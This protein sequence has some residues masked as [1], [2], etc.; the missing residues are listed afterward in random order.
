LKEMTE[1]SE[2]GS[3]IVG[4]YCIFAP[5]ELVRAA[6]AVPVDLCGKQQAP[7]AAA[8]E[9]LPPALCP[10]IKASYGYAVTDT[11]PFFASAD[12]IIAETTCDGKKRCLSLWL[13]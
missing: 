1:A 5:V 9:V 11:C 10:L 2:A 8:E 6:G 4:I 12:F 3:K 7:I 13:I